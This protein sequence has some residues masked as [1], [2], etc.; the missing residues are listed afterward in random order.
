MFAAAHT[1]YIWFI[2]GS[3]HAP[4]RDKNN[5]T[6]LMFFESPLTAH[7]PLFYAHI[8]F[9]VINLQWTI[10]LVN[11]NKM[12]GMLLNIV[13]LQVHKKHIRLGQTSNFS[14]DKPNLVVTEKFDVWLSEVRVW[15]VQ[16][17]L[18]ICLLLTDRASEVPLR[19]QLSIFTQATN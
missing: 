10:L 19:E 12:I 3:T 9:D 1:M 13:Y 4:S 8:N 5:L 6:E 15:N 17:I 14:W 16:H 18:L 2:H 7:N 11:K